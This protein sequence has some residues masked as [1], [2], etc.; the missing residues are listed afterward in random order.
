[1]CYKRDENDYC[2][3]F[4]MYVYVTHQVDDDCMIR[5]KKRKENESNQ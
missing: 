5:E 1:M 2:S 4:A 3:I